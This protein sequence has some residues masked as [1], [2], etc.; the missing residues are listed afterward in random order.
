MK[1]IK[2]FALCSALT[3]ATAC[4]DNTTVTN[5]GSSSTGEVKTA[6]SLPQAQAIIDAIDAAAK[7]QLAH[8]TDFASYVPSLVHR[9]E[10]P[11]GW[12][13]GT[14]FLGLSRWALATDNQ[15]YFD[16]LRNHG[17]EQQWQLGPR[18][19]HADDHVIAQYYLHMYDKD[20]QQT[21]IAPTIAVFDKILANQPDMSLDFGPVGKYRDQDYE[22][23]C[24]KRWCWSDALFMS[25][26]V[27]FHLT[28]ITGDDKYAV[29]AHKEF[30]AVTDYLFDSNDNLYV[31][32]SRFFDRR[33]ANGKKIYWSRG[34][35]WVF[36]GL[37]KILDTLE[38]DD[39][40]YAYYAGIFKK[41]ATSLAQKQAD[42]GYWPVS[43]AA[44][45]IYSVDESS[46]TAFFVA[47]LAWGVNNGLLD[48]DAYLPI[49]NKGWQALVN[50]QRD[51][52]MLGSV[53]QIGFAPDKVSEDETQLYG[54]GAFLLAGVQMLE[55]AQN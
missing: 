10:E 30:Q 46:G 11:R 53:Q 45:D 16:Y 21:Q 39:P 36:A 27:W 28:R 37:T 54:A 20:K 7:W 32:D 14:F 1:I 9:T 55:L 24:Q 34:N 6:Q 23:D 31:R 49:I 33:E 38:K 5:V 29:Y 44:G 4:T 35:G 48:D 50:A 3:V 43:L 47:G 2:L 26:P 12:V 8:M 40:R 17:E 18:D 52:G 42:D 19:F 22:H 15:A 41:M 51:D 13:Q 25:P